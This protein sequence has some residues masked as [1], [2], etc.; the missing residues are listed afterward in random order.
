MK[1][2][3]WDLIVLGVLGSVSV[4][5]AEP[6]RDV[7]TLLS[8]IESFVTC[9]ESVEDKKFEFE[10]YLTRLSGL[11][12]APSHS[13]SPQTLDRLWYLFYKTNPQLC[14]P[15]W[16]LKFG[17]EFSYDGQLISKGLQDHGG[18]TPD[19]LN[20][21]DSYFHKLILDDKTEI[22]QRFSFSCL[23]GHIYTWNQNLARENTDLD[24][25]AS[26]AEQTKIIIKYIWTDP[27]FPEFKEFKKTLSER[28]FEVLN[29]SILDRKMKVFLATYGRN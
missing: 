5:A 21:L 4:K 17:D 14:L 28:E 6:L 8:P 24:I 16:K 7:D 3:F 10:L 22:G 11:N 13:L 18:Y 25:N 29:L 12:N 19:A 26:S 23:L 15:E 9:D 20:K 2:I 1:R 27:L